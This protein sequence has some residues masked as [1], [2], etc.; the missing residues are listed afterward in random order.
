MSFFFDGVNDLLTDSTNGGVSL[1]VDIYTV[2]VWA[3]PVTFGG[4]NQ[5]RLIGRTSSTSRGS[6][7]MNLLFNSDSANTS[8]A[9]SLNQGRGT[10]YD[11]AEGSNAVTLGQWNCIVGTYS[12]GAVP[13]AAMY[14]N[15]ANTSGTRVDVTG[16]I[17]YNEASLFA[18][19]GVTNTTARS[20]YGRLAHAA[21]W[22]RV[23]TGAEI[24]ALA[25]GDT[26]LV[27]AP[28]GL[29]R[30]WPLTSSGTQVDTQGSGHN[31]VAS[32]GALY[33]T[34]DP[35]GAQPPLTDY[36]VEVLSTNPAFY[37][38][39]EEASAFGTYLNSATG[40]YWT[41]RTDWNLDVPGPTGL[42]S[43]VDANAL[44]GSNTGVVRSS[45]NFSC[46]GWIKWDGTAAEHLFYSGTYQVDGFRMGVGSNGRPFLMFGA[47][48]GDGYVETT[49][50][51]PVDEWSYVVTTWNGTTGRIYV[52][53]VEA[54]TQLPGPPLSQVWVVGRE[55]GVLGGGGW[56]C[57][58]PMDELA[59]HEG[60][61]LTAANVAARYAAAAP[62]AP[63][64]V[65]LVTTTIRG[66]GDQALET[67]LVNAGYTVTQRNDSLAMPVET[68]DG[69]VIA[70]SVSSSA[71]GNKYS[72]RT[73]P[74]MMMESVNIRSGTYTWKL[75]TSA[76]GGSDTANNST[77][78]AVTPVLNNR[79]TGAYQ[80][81]TTGAAHWGRVT[82]I[83][84]SAQK[85]LVTT[86][87]LTRCSGFSLVQ[88]DLLADGVTP[89]SWAR[90][91]FLGFG[92]GAAATLT[93]AGQDIFLSAVAWMLE[94][95][96]AYRYDAQYRITGNP[97]WT[98]VENIGNEPWV[99]SGLA[100]GTQYEAQFRAY[101]TE[102]N[103]PSPWSTS[104][105]ATTAGGRVVSDWSDP[106]SGTT[107]DVMAPN[108][109][110]HGQSAS[111]PALV[112]TYI[113]VPEP[114]SHTHVADQ[115]TLRLMS[116]WSDPVAGTTFEVMA[117]NN[118]RHGHTAS[119]PALTQIY[120]FV[121]ESA[122]HAQA[123]GEPLARHLSA[124]SAPVAGTTQSGTATLTPNNAQHGHTASSP[125]LQVKVALAPN[126]AQHGH[127]ASSPAL[128]VKVALAPNNAQHTHTA[129]SPALQVKV[130]LTP[131]SARHVQTASSPAIAQAHKL[132]PNGAQH[133]QTA[134]SP[135]LALLVG[136]APNGARH[137]HTATSPA[138]AQAS[139]LSPDG[140]THRHAANFVNSYP[141]QVLS[142]SPMYYWRFEETS[143]STV[144][145]E[146]VSE[147]GTVVGA[148][149]TPALKQRLGTGVSFDGVDDYVNLGT[150]GTFGSRPQKSLALWVKLEEGVSDDAVLLGGYGTTPSDGFSELFLYRS[151]VSINGSTYLLYVASASDGTNQDYRFLESTFIR[152]ESLVNGR[153][154]L[155]VFSVDADTGIVNTWLDGISLDTSYNTGNEPFALFDY[156]ADIYL[157]AGNQ[158][159]TP[160]LFHASE[161]DELA[162]FDYLL[163]QAD[164]DALYAAGSETDIRHLSAWS[165]PVAGTTD[166]PPAQL[167]PDDASHAQTASSPALTVNVSLAPSNA[168]HT[169]TAS[170]P[171]LVQTYKLAPA[172]APHTHT[173]SSPALAVTYALAP[174]SA[175]H[176]QTA[177]SPALT[178]K[179]V[180]GPDGASHTQTATSPA[181]AQA[182][183]LHPQDA[184]HIQTVLSPT[185][186][187]THLLAPNAAS[188]GQTAESPGL[189]VT[190]SL[191]PDG[192]QHG[193]TAETTTL[194]LYDP[195][196]LTLT[197]VGPDVLLEWP[198]P[199]M[200]GTTHVA[201]FR[202]PGLG[203]TP[204][205]D[206]GAD[207][208]IGRVPVAT[209]EYTDIAPEVGDYAY[210]VFPV[211]VS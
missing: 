168:A 108:D 27:A 50:P 202:R 26:P 143:G 189:L 132:Q 46:E 211:V 139:V 162:L 109:A 90:F 158:V 10:G 84:A 205:F 87:D 34:D 142:R 45:P 191:S 113:L 99:L 145:D 104:V 156:T 92:D 51:I 138:L 190:I 58:S 181:I 44:G 206:P 175:R 24:A 75:M 79:A 114:A 194:T 28:S 180:L 121:P 83:V 130:S 186:T 9:A 164:V 53:G 43:G 119:S 159:G 117:P 198:A 48:G 66:A 125:A 16:S 106:V 193:H 89:A 20:Y 179:H 65:L 25:A 35:L 21:I 73:E 29:L 82:D 160:G 98:Y 153:A 86:S 136:L 91:V 165:A 195:I 77:V 88:G 149:L 56:N 107:F 61:V 103:I 174:N 14:V 81:S 148:D 199:V 36:A 59:Y 3:K 183:K 137:G 33:D 38:R 140:A 11:R 133:T 154:H 23:L 1:N 13:R 69:I 95:T 55:V 100:Y 192:A 196:D 178:Q 78:T 187:Q 52:N 41:G 118:A 32:G 62:V 172:S 57:R 72:T 60:Y 146:I 208:E 120:V 209:L 128:Q 152:A 124:W 188:H 157:G 163:T 6:S 203:L 76:D 15:G 93:A 177:T 17:L 169:H 207:T 85:F 37:A 40:G 4:S 110:R 42:G 141:T 210:Q 68:Y 204:L 167:S 112:E 170:S 19:G 173:A 2:M 30:Y 155:L 12:G 150:L 105:L 5:A 67:L 74:L 115:L 151:E 18:L 197:Q 171:T 8:S 144:T 102:T 131:N 64:Q 71:L 129:T 94:T 184:A 176:A 39:F 49:A 63:K 126:N 70:E 127:T 134:S 22:N 97:T 185:I 200:P 182:H 80:T 147:V 96:T 47:E 111:S 123:A 116:A 7:H 161:I 135:A 166:A 31:L 101:D 201:I 54:A 122:A